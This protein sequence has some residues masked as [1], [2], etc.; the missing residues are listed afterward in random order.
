MAT[1][2]V[3]PLQEDVV[4]LGK[5]RRGK[6]RALVTIPWSEFFSDLAGRVASTAQAIKSVVL[7]G[8]SASIGNTAIPTGALAAGTYRV[9]TYARI[10]RAAT[11]SSSLQITITWT[12]GGVT[13]SSTSAALTGNTTSTTQS[14]TLVLT[15]DQGVAVSYSTTYATLGVTTMT[16]SLNVILEAL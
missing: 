4:S 2:T 1:E 11:T 5:D 13:C 7:T 3:Q 8:Q 9:S 10:T 12:D 14:Q 6:V 16:Y 15:S